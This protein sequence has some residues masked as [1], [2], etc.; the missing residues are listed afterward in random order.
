MN[1]QQQI[2]HISARLDAIVRCSDELFLNRKQIADLYDS[3]L[4]SEHFYPRPG[5]VFKK[6]VS[7]TLRK[8][9]CT[10][11][12]SKIKPK[13]M[14]AYVRDSKVHLRAYGNKLRRWLKENEID[15]QNNISV[16]DL[17]PTI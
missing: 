6:H 12:P 13:Q 16:H 7:L 17:E 1:K 2:A 9:V 3:I 11:C 10:Y 15:D 4:A 8:D 14:D 5:L